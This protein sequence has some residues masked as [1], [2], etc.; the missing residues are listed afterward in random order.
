MAGY[1]QDTKGQKPRGKLVNYDYDPVK[2]ICSYHLYNTDFCFFSWRNTYAITAVVVMSRNPC[3]CAT[4]VTTVTTPSALCHP[5]RRSQKVTGVVLNVSRRKSQSPQKHSGS[6]RHSV[7]THCSSSGKWQI[8]S[9][10]SISTCLS[11]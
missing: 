4:V 3:C 8:S 6:N 5:W 1:N 7:N 2:Y 10:Q 9:S 11:M